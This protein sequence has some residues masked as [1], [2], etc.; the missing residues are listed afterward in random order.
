MGLGG[1]CNAAVALA[2]ALAFPAAAD[3]HR[4][5]V[6]RLVAMSTA[7]RDEARALSEKG[8]L[9]IDVQSRMAAPECAELFQDL[10]S[11]RN[12]QAV[13]AVAGDLLIKWHG[14]RELVLHMQ[15][16][17]GFELEV[18]DAAGQACAVTRVE[19]RETGGWQG[20]LT[21]MLLDIPGMK[22]G[23]AQVFVVDPARSPA[24]EALK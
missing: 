5:A 15:R 18:R 13:S 19:A 11:M 24:R 14:K 6:L 21:P 9:G 4:E 16:D 8:M 12:V 7:L 10:A 17:P 2:L 23:P 1:R 20:K 22:Q 3:S